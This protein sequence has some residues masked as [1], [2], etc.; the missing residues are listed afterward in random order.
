MLHGKVH[1]LIGSSGK[2]QLKTKTLQPIQHLSRSH[3]HRRPNHTRKLIL[4]SA[5]NPIICV[6]L[7]SSIGLSIINHITFILLHV[8]N[9]IQIA[10]QAAELNFGPGFTR[11]VTVK[12]AVVVWVAKAV[13]LVVVEMVVTFS[14]VIVVRC[15]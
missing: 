9:F 7:S 14:V 3:H 15:L 8:L 10:K 6:F 12:V 4:K 1:C 11:T 5:A 2:A 13:V